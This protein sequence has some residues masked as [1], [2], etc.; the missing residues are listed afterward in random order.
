MGSIY[1]FRVEVRLNG[2]PPKTYDFLEDSRADARS[3]AE[4][5]GCEGFWV[6]DADP[7]IFI[8]PS[9]I[10]LVRIFRIDRKRT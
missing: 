4:E 9:R 1:M 10:E 8:P 5:I 3:R 7:P 6:D 2:A